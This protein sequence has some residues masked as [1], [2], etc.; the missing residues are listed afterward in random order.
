MP[1]YGADYCGYGCMRDEILVPHASILAAESINSH[2]LYKNLLSF[3]ALGARQPVTDGIQTTDFG[4]RASLNWSTH[5]VTTTYLVLDQGM[6]FLSLVN[7]IDNKNIRKLFCQDEITRQAI[8][9]IP[10]YS[11]SCT[12]LESSIT[13]T[14][15]NGGQNWYAGTTKKIKW[16]YT[17]N[18]GSRVKIDLLKGK[19][20]IGTINSNVSIGKNGNGS[21]KWSIN[22][23]QQPGNYKIRITS[24]SN[25][26]YKDKSNKNFTILPQKSNGTIKIA[27]FNL[28][29]FGVT[30]AEKPE[31]MDVLSKTIR[32]FDIVAVPGDPGRFADSS[33]S[34]QK[35]R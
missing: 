26:I 20:K 32:N 25:P 30:K 24:K 35:C 13:V 7:K 23:T 16:K 5:E 31:V 18:P 11:K 28:H 10:D 29:I 6:A 17:G 33:T 12:A 3:D 1:P 4:F 22:S 2:E 9:L 15:P 8:K 34:S 27:S 14:V 19:K 21:Y